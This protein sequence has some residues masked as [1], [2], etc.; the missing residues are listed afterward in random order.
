MRRV[1]LFK[2]IARKRTKGN[3][4]SLLY[5]QMFLLLVTVFCLLDYRSMLLNTSYNYIDDSV[6]ASILGGAI[7]NVEEYG[8]SNQLILHR[9]DKF[10][11]STSSGLMVKG[12]LPWEYD[13]LVSERNYESDV[14]IQ[15]SDLDN[16][17][18]K[19]INVRGNQ[20][21]NYSDEYTRRCLSAIV[22]NL[23]YN[24]S[25]GVVE[26]SVDSENSVASLSSI[27][28]ISDLL[29]LDIKNKMPNSFLNKY[30]LGGIEVTRLEL[31]N[32]YKE[33]YAKKHRYMSY[34]ISWSGDT[35]T[36][37][38]PVNAAA[39]LIAYNTLSI[40]KHEYSKAYTDAFNQ[41]QKDL[42]I[43]NQGIAGTRSLIMYTDTG[44]TYQDVYDSSK[45]DYNY[46][47]TGDSL[48]ADE[49]NDGD[50]MPIDGYSVYAYT[51]NKSSYGYSNSIGYN[52]NDLAYG[53]DSITL[54]GG[55]MGGQ[56]IS[57]TALYIEVTFTFEI[58]PQSI[59]TSIAAGSRQLTIAKLIDIEIDNNK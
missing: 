41:W 53:T 22:G 48:V 24:I 29:K 39:F 9:G 23:N 27:N 18:E 28:A 55:K 11:N 37:T 33:T 43:Y 19:D 4:T 54:N 46:I 50:K 44:I 45:S 59:D 49:I 21:D 35:A 16:K 30:L 12:W 47:W 58:F 36:W 57:N 8:S 15:A 7:V 13:I 20:T 52:Y 34:Y 17:K 6:T 56:K 25:N 51:S 1:D 38:G 31:Y 5:G 10:I 40:N 14:Q 32:V 3:V 42:N 26:S 2:R